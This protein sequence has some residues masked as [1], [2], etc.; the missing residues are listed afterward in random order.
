[1]NKEQLARLLRD[2]HGQF[3]HQLKNLGDA[4][5]CYVPE[6]K[7]SAAQHLDHIYRSVAPVNLALW[8]PKFFIRRKFGLANRPSKTYEELIEKYKQK[9]SEGG[10]AI[11]PFIP[12]VVT[13]DKKAVLLRRVHRVATKL[14]NKTINHSEEALDKYILPHPLLGKL[15][16]R[17]MLYFTAY[18]VQ[19]HR[20]LVQRGLDTK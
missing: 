3:F 18:H 2:N 6:G 11:G 13:A 8:I 1:M 19:H 16:L 20:E 4:D 7:W 15:T 10:K 9:L 17:E 12:E 5:F 14:C